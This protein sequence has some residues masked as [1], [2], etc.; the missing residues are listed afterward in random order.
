MER[1][2]HITKNNLKKIAKLNLKKI[3]EAEGKFL[4]D[5]KQLIAEALNS[6]WQMEAL[7]VRNDMLVDPETINLVNKASKLNIQTFNVDI[8]DFNRI[9][10]TVTPQGVIAVIQK[11]IYKLN[12]HTESGIKDDIIV[13]LDKISDPGNLGTII[14]IC[15]WFRIETVLLG[16]GTVEL[17]NPKV[18]RSTMGSIFHVK[19]YQDFD[20][21]YLLSQLK[22]IGYKIFSTNLKGTLLH[23]L[24]FYDKAVFIFGNEAHGVSEEL[25]NISDDKITIPK[26]GKAESLNVAVACGIILSDYKNKGSK[27]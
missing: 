3:R 24:R 19:I 10:N 17:F 21:L 18:V 23:N 9:V 12:Q 15:D 14:R 1:I 27:R 8:K 25:K 2:K 26:Y 7:L 22:K 5:G 6:D 13:Y 4:I 16:P 20:S 11:K